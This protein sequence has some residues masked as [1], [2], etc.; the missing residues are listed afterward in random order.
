MFDSALH[1]WTPGDEFLFGVP[2]HGKVQA[3]PGEYE[4][5]IWLPNGQFAP[6]PANDVL[7]AKGCQW[8]RDPRAKP[9]ERTPEQQAEDKKLGVEWR[10][11]VLFDYAQRHVHLRSEWEQS[12]PADTKWLYSDGEQV[13]M[14]GIFG[15]ESSR[16]LRLSPQPI[17][18][19]SPE[20]DV[21][22][23]S[24]HEVIPLTE[25]V[26]AEWG[27]VGQLEISDTTRDGSR[28]LL[29]S[30]AR[31]EYVS[32]LYDPDGGPTKERPGARWFELVISTE[33]DDETGKRTHKAHLTEINLEWSS[34]QSYSDN[35]DHGWV[36]ARQ[37]GGATTMETDTMRAGYTSYGTETGVGDVP[38]GAVLFTVGGSHRLTYQ[39]R[40]AAC[41]YFYDAED[42]PVPIRFDV[43]FAEIFTMS[44]PSGGDHSEDTEWVQYAP[45]WA[46]EVTK[47]GGAR[48]SGGG[49]GSLS[50]TS[51]MR[52]SAPGASTSI[53]YTGHATFTD[54]LDWDWTGTVG[55]GHLSTSNAVQW[56]QKA[57]MD[58]VLLHSASGGEGSSRGSY[59]SHLY[60]PA[61]NANY[62]T[63]KD[64][65]G[66]EYSLRLLALNI[67]QLIVK[68]YE[69][70]YVLTSIRAGR[71][72]YFDKVGGEVKQYAKPAVLPPLQ[73]AY[74]RITDELATSDKGFV[75]FV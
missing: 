2:W 23:R 42:K 41:G 68:R 43:D 15:G 56:E 39:V 69:G 31:N 65:V 27:Y 61:S 73:V 75:G 14:V 48:W 18:R 62:S 8:F 49:S 72:F 30:G 47:Q 64:K 59:A 17:L 13:F 33:V 5:S 38:G 60:L 51:E 29:S 67:G 19:R 6:Y 40:N 37:T 24:L 26:K 46:F 55:V 54:T 35:Y 57:F 4:L 32:Y 25:T 11:D 63:F 70:D 21:R 12:I 74:N 28:V 52:V 7:T 10:P 22:D 58:G 44:G 53:K 45:N 9:V 50:I 36:L 66:L 3:R 20:E 71:F 16:T 34:T 1:D